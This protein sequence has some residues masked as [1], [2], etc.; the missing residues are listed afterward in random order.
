MFFLSRDID[1]SKNLRENATL[2]AP[3]ILHDQAKRPSLG[4]ESCI[5]EFEI[6]NDDSTRL[7][8]TTASVLSWDDLKLV[9]GE[10]CRYLSFIYD[11]GGTRHGV[12]LVRIEFLDE[13]H[14]FS[15]TSADQIAECLDPL[16]E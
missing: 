8:K 11:T 3:P 9:I 10:E 14:A 5:L 6:G 16:S 1:G 7:I 4:G 12:R 2:K 13:V 15:H